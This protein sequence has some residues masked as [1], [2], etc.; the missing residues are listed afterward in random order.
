MWRMN[1]RDPK[2][3]YPISLWIDKNGDIKIKAAGGL[4][5]ELTIFVTT[6][7]PILLPIKI[8]S[9]SLILS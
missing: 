4:L 1:F 5:K 9:F 7:V 2:N 6:P 8:K 3:C